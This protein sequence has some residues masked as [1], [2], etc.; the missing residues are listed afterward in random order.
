MLLFII[1]LPLYLAMLA[2][3]IP[4]EMIVP[5]ALQ[6][7]IDSLDD[8]ADMQWAV[9]VHTPREYHQRIMD[10]RN[11]YKRGDQ[12]PWTSPSTC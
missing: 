5:L 3:D 8:L 7:R 4:E 12:T 10:L 11:S 2:H 6:L 1:E 9:A